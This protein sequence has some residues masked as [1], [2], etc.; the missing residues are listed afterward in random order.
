[1]SPSLYDVFQPLSCIN[2]VPR[3]VPAG[4]VLFCTL[5]KFSGGLR[6]RIGFIS[7]NISCWAAIPWEGEMFHDLS[8]LDLGFGHF[9]ND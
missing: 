7:Q 9:V 6:G 5:W 4:L 3:V 8:E 2:K 1:M